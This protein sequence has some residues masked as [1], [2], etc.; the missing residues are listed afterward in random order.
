M[1]SC[2]SLSAL[3]IFCVLLLDVC[4]IGES[5][6]IFTPSRLVLG[7]VKVYHAQGWLIRSVIVDGSWSAVGC[8]TSGAVNIDNSLLFVAV[9][10]RAL[11]GHTP[12]SP[13]DRDKQKK[14][15]D[16]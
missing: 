16:S 7:F 5:I 13:T 2:R 3:T 12:H 9:H 6:A 10:R 14:Y 15:S 8:G 4:R 11:L 1:Q